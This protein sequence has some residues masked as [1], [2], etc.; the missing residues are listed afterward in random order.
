[1]RK[2]ID[3]PKIDYVIYHLKLRCSLTEEILDKFTFLQDG[4]LSE[5]DHASIVFPLSK[6]SYTTSR[7]INDI[8][9]L[10]PVFLN[11][12]EHFFVQDSSV[13]FS[14]DILKEIFCLQTLY[15]EQE[16]KERDKLGRIIP[17]KTLNYKLNFI[18]KPLV[19]YLFDI[20]IQGI[21][22]FCKIHNIAFTK[23]NLLDRHTFLLSHDVDR[24]DSYSFYNT[25]NSIKLFCKKPSLNSYH[26][27]AKHLKQFLS[28]SQKDN[29]LW[30]FP[31]LRQIEEQY[32]LNSTYYF[33]NQGKLHQ[34]AYYKLSDPKIL[35]LIK[36]IED[37]NNEVG[38]H[39][40]IAGNTDKEILQ[41]NLKLLNKVT[42]NNSLG[43]RSHWLRFEPTLTADILADLKLKYDTSIGHYSIQGFRAGTCLPYK[44]FSFSQNKLLDIWEFPLIFMDCM[45][46]DYQDISEEEALNKLQKLLEEVIK[47]K[48]IF[49]I[50]WHNGNFALDKPY[51]RKNFYIKLI[52]MIVDSKAVNLTGISLVNKL[53]EK[54]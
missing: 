48:G 1:M 7:Q 21:S 26:D 39:L 51:N 11:K 9:I 52:E 45:I 32:K 5:I 37:D 2:Y 31:Q 13:I 23:K 53:E 17:E 6:D 49:S 46:L 22:D 35:N 38:I 20:I 50:L 34:D 30:D 12:N 33:L 15:Y 24:I 18:D 43:A 47:F 44:L 8:P 42:R 40:T 29:P 36:T 41:K 54:I 14:H 19:D 16:I 4:D 28:F 27:M 25:L 10:Y 3:R